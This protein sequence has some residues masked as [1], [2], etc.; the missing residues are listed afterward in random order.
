MILFG[1]QGAAYGYKRTV[2]EYLTCKMNLLI[3]LKEDPLEVAKTV[4][5]FETEIFIN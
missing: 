4:R 5:C 2:I 1:Y 3:M